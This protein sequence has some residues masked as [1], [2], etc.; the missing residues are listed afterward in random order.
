MRQSQA[1]RSSHCLSHLVCLIRSAYQS[2]HA[3]VQHPLTRPHGSRTSTRAQSC[4]SRYEVARFGLIA[5]HAS[6]QLA[7]RA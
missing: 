5:V 1:T 3:D 2:I 6:W 4:A 7:L